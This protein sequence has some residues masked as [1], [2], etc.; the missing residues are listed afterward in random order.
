MFTT[1]L[2]PLFAA[3]L[4]ALGGTGAAAADT[5]PLPERLSQTGLYV[6][7]STRTVRPGVEPR[8]DRCRSRDPT[9]DKTTPGD[10]TGSR[11]GARERSASKPGST[12]VPKGARGWDRVALGAPCRKLCQNL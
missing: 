5:D 12:G 3:P 7:G 1:R 8:L 2:L 9:G 6:P 10:T 4:L 11:P